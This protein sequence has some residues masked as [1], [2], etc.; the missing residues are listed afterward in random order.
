MT[1]D[2]KIYQEL[3]QAL[4]DGINTDWESAKVIVQRATG[5]RTRSS[6][7]RVNNNSEWISFDDNIGFIQFRNWMK[8]L[9]EYTESHSFK[10]WN[11]LT[12]EINSEGK[13]DAVFD[14][15]EEYQS[16]I[17]NRL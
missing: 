17:E 7:Y 12:L 9:F 10:K 6:W 2:I 11:T 16:E 8:E 5:R 1:T 14:W 15:D 4:V 3:T 13:F